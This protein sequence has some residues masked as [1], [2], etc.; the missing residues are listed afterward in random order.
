MKR[1]VAHHET[2]ILGIFGNDALHRRIEGAAGLAR[3][4]E[5]F[6]DGDGRILGADNWRVRTNEA[7]DGPCHDLFRGFALGGSAVEY[8][9]AGA[10]VGREAKSGHGIDTCVHDFSLP[11]NV[12]TRVEDEHE[13][14]GGW[15]KE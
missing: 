11:W 13:V 7:V 15:G 1:Q 5:E 10:G 9:A 3:G 4:V 12:R 2:H 8:R 14:E 6:D